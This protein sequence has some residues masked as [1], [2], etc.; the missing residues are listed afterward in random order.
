M[1]AARTARKF[2]FVVALFTLGLAS[3]AQENARWEYLGEANVDGATDHDRITVT[4]E[5][6][7]F[8]AIHLKV[9]IAAIEFDR[10]I[11][12]YGNGSSEPIFIRARI[13][14]GG[15]TRVIDLPGGRRIIRSV[16][17][18]YDRANPGGNRPKVRLFGLH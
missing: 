12:H 5:R 6:G 3:H 8:R 1:V 14:A 4:G 11:V 2:G 7:R 13:P 17:F 9:E 10:V 18:W 15:Q 16:E